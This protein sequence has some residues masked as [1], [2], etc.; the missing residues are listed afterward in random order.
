VAS[1]PGSDTAPIAPVSLAKASPMMA[2]P[3]EAPPVFAIAAAAVALVALGV[4]IWT[5]LG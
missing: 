4:Q 1:K 5:M 2:G 3:Q